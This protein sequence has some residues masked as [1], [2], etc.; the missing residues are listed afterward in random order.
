LLKEIARQLQPLIEVE[1]WTRAQQ[2]TI[3]LMFP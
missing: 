3:S 1:D 2:A